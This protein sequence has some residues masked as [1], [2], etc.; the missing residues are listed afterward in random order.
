MFEPHTSEAEAFEVEMFLISY[1]GRKDL[2]TGCLRNLTDGGDGASGYKHTPETSLKM[3]AAQK[4]NT[5]TRGKKKSP[6]IR[7]NM[8]LAQLGKPKPQCRGNKSRTGKKNSLKW[9]RRMR[10]VMTG[11]VLPTRGRPWSPARRAAYK[12]G[13]GLRAK[14]A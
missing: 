8:S 12:N 5:K 14:I 4:G 9:V 6:E 2:G 7:L 11:K 10:E 1:Y 3:T 13:V